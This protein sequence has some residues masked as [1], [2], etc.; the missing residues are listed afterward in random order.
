VCPMED[1]ERELRKVILLLVNSHKMY[2]VRSLMQGAGLQK[3]MELIQ[4][5]RKDL[6][7]IRAAQEQAQTVGDAEANKQAQSLENALAGEEP[8]L[9]LLRVYAS[10]QSWK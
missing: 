7:Y 3:A 9:E 6:G 8:F 4:S 2:Q 5:G 10:R 1:S